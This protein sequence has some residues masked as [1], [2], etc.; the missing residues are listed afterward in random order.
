LEAE[1]PGAFGERVYGAVAEFELIVFDTGILAGFTVL[2]HA[3]EDAS[4][5]VWR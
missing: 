1:G 3:E 2:P 4:N 5:P